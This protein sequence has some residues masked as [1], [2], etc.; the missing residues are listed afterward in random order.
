M[1][2]SMAAS[3]SNQV[4]GPPCQARALISLNPGLGLP[5]N[6]LLHQV[7]HNTHF[8]FQLRSMLSFFVKGVPLSHC[9][10]FVHSLNRRL[11]LHSCALPAQATRVRLF[12]G[13]CQ[14]LALS[15]CG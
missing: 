2:T 9:L 4:S 15:G 11:S 12:T 7:Q 13:I 6:A 3:L 8:E 5:S 1:C 14:A 10:H